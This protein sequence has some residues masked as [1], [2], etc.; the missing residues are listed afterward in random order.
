MF[1]ARVI[2]GRCPRGKR[3]EDLVELAQ[4]YLIDLLHNGQIRRYHLDWCG[5]RLTGHIEVPRPDSFAKRFLPKDR[6]ARERLEAVSRTFGRPPAWTLLSDDAPTRFP[7]WRS[8]RFLY[9]HHGVLDEESSPVYRGDDAVP[10]PTYLLPA[11]ARKGLGHWLESTRRH[12][13]VWIDS[14]DLEIPAYEQLATTDS[15]LGTMGR[16]L[17]RSIERATGIPTYYFLKKYYARKGD[18]DR[19]C[20]GCGRKWR[21]PADGPPCSRFIQ[22]LCKRCRLVSE[23]GDDIASPRLARIG[24]Y[25]GATR[26]RRRS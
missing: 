26:R 16:K 14:H 22:F 9:L 21:L 23:Q 11:G 20:P 10:V 18:E 24:E 25:R 12:Y 8:A 3:R 7:S 5:G 19:P 15:G 2:F 6:H 17:C 1:I 4:Y 13:W